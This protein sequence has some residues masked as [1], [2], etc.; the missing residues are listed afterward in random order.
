LHQ[1]YIEAFLLLLGFHKPLII[2]IIN[3]DILLKFFLWYLPSSFFLP[4]LLHSHWILSP[5][6]PC[7]KSSLWPHLHGSRL[8]V[9]PPCLWALWWS[10]FDKITIKSTKC[11]GN[12]I[13]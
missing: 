6:Y 4:S 2:N 1:L 8:F 12:N 13:C 9:H 3:L 11:A 10:C 7:W 5:H